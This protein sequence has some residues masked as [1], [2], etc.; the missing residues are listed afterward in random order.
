MSN[1]FT[2]IL[3]YFNENKKDKSLSWLEFSK[4]FTEEKNVGK[5]FISSIT[6]LPVV[7]KI[8]Q[9]MDHSNKRE[10][11]IMK[12]LNEM[13]DYCP[14]FCR[15]YDS[16]DH[17]I[18]VDYSMNKN[19]FKVTQKYPIVCQT[20]IMEYISG[21]SIYDYLEKNGFKIRTVLSFIKQ[22]LIALSIAQTNENFTHYDLHHSNVLVKSCDKD[23]VHLYVL[24]D[25]NQI[26]IPTFGRIPIMVDFE[27]SHI[28]NLDN[29]YTKFW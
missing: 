29:M 28:K 20:N 6:N 15:I 12:K 2:S 22:I 1:D 4:C 19:P 27:Y 14:H 16:I 11:I 17:S 5:L 7:Y 21:P 9:F 26:C 10:E 13:Y 18:N 3:K 25:V 24:D 8:P 23:D